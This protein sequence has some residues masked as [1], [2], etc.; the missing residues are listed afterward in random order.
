MLLAAGQVVDTTKGVLV[1]TTGQAMPH[2]FNTEEEHLSLSPV[3]AAGHRLWLKG[4][5]AFQM[6][7]L[8]KSSHRIHNSSLFSPRSSAPKTGR[9]K[10]HAVIILMFPHSG[11]LHMAKIIPGLVA[12]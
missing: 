3:S 2:L 6:L 8:G 12:T 10:E 11:P 4:W 5:S 9:D 1:P 7:Y